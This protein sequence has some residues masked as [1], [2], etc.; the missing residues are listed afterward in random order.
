MASEAK[1]EIIKGTWLKIL[2]PKQMLQRLP[3]TLAPVKADNNSEDLWNQKTV[4]IK[5][6]YLKS[7]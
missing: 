1:H 3:I 6:N 7:I 5:R 2:I 4:S